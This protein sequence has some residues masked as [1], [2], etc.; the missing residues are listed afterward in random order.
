MTFVKVIFTSISDARIFPSYGSRNSYLRSKRMKKKVKPHTG[1]INTSVKVLQR[2]IQID[3][4]LRTKL[5]RWTQVDF[6]SC[7][8]T[9]GSDY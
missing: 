8:S 1:K 3:L 9:K 5:R 4:I 6:P 2:H 7:Q